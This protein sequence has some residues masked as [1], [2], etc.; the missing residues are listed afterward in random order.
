MNSIFLPKNITIDFNPDID[1]Q[2]D[3]EKIV[4][5]SYQKNQ[6][7]FG[8]EKILEFLKNITFSSH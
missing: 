8:E 2:K 1:S 7:F 6:D 3:L 5:D 4:S